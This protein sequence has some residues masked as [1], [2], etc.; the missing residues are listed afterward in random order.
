MQYKIALCCIYSPKINLNNTV[1]VIN[2]PKMKANHTY[3]FVAT[4]DFN[5]NIMNNL[6]TVSKEFL[7]EL[8]NLEFHQAITLLTRIMR[9]IG[10]LIDNSMYDFALL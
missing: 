10:I 6:T 2:S 9:T 1:S 7:N 4:G 3:N 5:I 8:Y